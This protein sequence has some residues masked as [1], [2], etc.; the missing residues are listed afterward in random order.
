MYTNNG[1]EAIINPGHVKRRKRVYCKQ[2]YRIT[3]KIIGNEQISRKV[4]LLN[5]TQEEIENLNCLITN[6][7]I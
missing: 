1:D 7:G 5:I 6:T 2:L 3:L 4:Y